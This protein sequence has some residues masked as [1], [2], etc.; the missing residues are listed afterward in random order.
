MLPSSL[1]KIQTTRYSLDKAKELLNQFLSEKNYTATLNQF[2]RKNKRLI[3][4]KQEPRINK[5]VYKIF[6]TYASLYT[7]QE[8]K[9]FIKAIK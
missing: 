4:T 2:I 7:Q 1:E 6:E 5:Y 3:V 9:D 8:E